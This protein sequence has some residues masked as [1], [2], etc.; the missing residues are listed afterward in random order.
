VSN[1]MLEPEF[2]GKWLIVRLCRDR[3]FAASGFR[4]EGSFLP[5]KAP[6]W[7]M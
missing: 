4:V 1:A 7:R 2:F 6:A 5:F 3:D